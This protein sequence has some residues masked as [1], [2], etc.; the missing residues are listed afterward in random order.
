MKLQRELEA[1]LAAHE[2][3]TQEG[4]ESESQRRDDLEKQG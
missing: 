2:K 1:A 3:A 4:K